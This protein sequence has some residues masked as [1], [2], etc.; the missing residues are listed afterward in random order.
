YF[1]PH[2]SLAA[3]E[4]LLGAAFL[5][6]VGLRLHACQMRAPPPPKLDLPEQKLPYY[7]VV[8]ALYREARVV[9][10]LVEALKQLD[11]PREKLELKPV[12][13]PDDSATLDAIRALK[14]DPYFEV[15]TA[16]LAGPRTKPKALAAALPFARGKFL[17]IYDAED[18]PE[19]DQLKKALA[20][21]YRGPK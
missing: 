12:C 8:V 1:F 11:Y 17:V 19:R 21:Y 2:Q 20:A 13:E 3:A 5:A 15:M 4:V 6:W 7:T 14:L 9:G 16:P 10:Q 18:L